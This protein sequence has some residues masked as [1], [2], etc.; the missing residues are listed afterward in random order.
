MLDLRAKTLTE[1]MLVAIAQSIA[2]LVDKD[3]LKED[4]VILKVDDPRILPVVSKTIKE[5]II[6]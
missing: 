1:E 5:N 2:S 4:Y 6:V 3:H